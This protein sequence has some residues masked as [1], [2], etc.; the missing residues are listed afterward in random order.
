MREFS[1]TDLGKRTG[2]VLDA[3]AQ[4]PVAI[5]RHRKARFAVLTTEEFERI[6]ASGDPRIAR[7]TADIPPEE[8]AKLIAALTRIFESSD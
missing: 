4:G 5:T 3:A 2:D 6:R 1:S 7:R 8:G